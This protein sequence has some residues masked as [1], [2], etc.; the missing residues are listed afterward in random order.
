MAKDGSFQ[1]GRILIRVAAAVA[2]VHLSA[3][4]AIAAGEQVFDVRAGQ[5]GKVL[6]EFGRQAGWSV[7]LTDPALARHRSDGVRG[8]HTPVQALRIL[9]RSPGA[10]FTMLD[11][12]SARIFAASRP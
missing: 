5:V 1:R 7:G 12:R 10:D 8:R 11:A 9:L 3:A 6:V 2:V 4:P